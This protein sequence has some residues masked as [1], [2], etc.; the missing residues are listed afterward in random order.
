MRCDQFM[1]L[2]KE[3]EQYLQTHRIPRDHCPTCHQSLPIKDMGQYDE[4][5]G[6]FDEIYPLH[7]FELTNNLY[8][9]EF[10]Q[11][12]LWSSGPCFF[13]GLRILNDKNETEKEFLHS[14]E[15]IDSA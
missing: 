7:R 10:I 6:M 13:M 14:Q 3:A 8:A 15:A 9:E 1:G 4:F 11:S 5:R 12:S 2:T